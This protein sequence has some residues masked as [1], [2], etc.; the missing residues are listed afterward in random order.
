MSRYYIRKTER[1]YGE[2]TNVI[3]SV[4]SKGKPFSVPDIPLDKSPLA[5]SQML[6]VMCRTGEL[7]RVRTWRAR[8]FT[9]YLT[10]DKQ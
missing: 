8:H 6:S 7:K 3:R 2:M 4:A 10:A 5:I 9:I 1:R